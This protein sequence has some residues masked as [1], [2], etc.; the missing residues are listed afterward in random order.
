VLTLA[1]C[2]R[3]GL[4]GLDATHLARRLLAM[5][6]PSSLDERPCCSDVMRMDHRQHVV[7]MRHKSLGAE[8]GSRDKPRQGRNR[9]LFRFVK[10]GNSQCSSLARAVADSH[11]LPSGNDTVR[12]YTEV[13]R[14]LPSLTFPSSFCDRNQPSATR[15]SQSARSPCSPP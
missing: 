14:R 4:G 10:L 13:A 5:P 11:N 2:A 6:V 1:R 9:H 15:S 12:E 7:R 8:D 3:N